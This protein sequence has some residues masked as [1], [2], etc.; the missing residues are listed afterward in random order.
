[1]E[2]DISSLHSRTS[3]EDELFS[4]KQR[5]PWLKL[6]YLHINMLFINCGIVF[7]M[8]VVSHLRYMVI[9][10]LD[11]PTVH[12]MSFSLMSFTTVGWLT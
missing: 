10:E 9:V 1:M 6:Q 2:L 11:R 5:Q 4:L 12:K 8:S 7:A 3:L